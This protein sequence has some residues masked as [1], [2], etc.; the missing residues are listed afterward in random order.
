M[1]SMSRVAVAAALAFGGIAVQSAGASAMPM[2]DTSPAVVAHSE[3]V[4][5]V[6]Q[7]RWHHGRHWGYGW[8]RHRPWGWHRHW[9]WHHRHWGW[10]HRHW[11]HH[12]YRW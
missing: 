9:G 1:L 12:G 10:R 5:G 11:R 8:H 4:S 7:A 2:V 3:D 6:T